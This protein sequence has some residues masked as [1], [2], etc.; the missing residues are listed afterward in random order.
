MYLFK[1]KKDFAYDNQKEYR[2]PGDVI[3]SYTLKGSALSDNDPLDI[4]SLNLRIPPNGIFVG[5]KG[6]EFKYKF[7]IKVDKP[8]TCL[9]YSPRDK[10]LWAYGI[11][12][13]RDETKLYENAC[14]G[15]KMELK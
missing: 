4:S 13:K 15:L 3:F 7:T 5:I 12:N 1:A 9:H 10:E 2:K 8:L 14:F 6:S 11:T